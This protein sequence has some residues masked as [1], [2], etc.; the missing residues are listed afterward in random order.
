MVMIQKSGS[1]KTT[2]AGHIRT[3]AVTGE[4][5]AFVGI[6]ILSRKRIYG[7]TAAKYIWVDCFWRRTARPTVRTPSRASTG[8]TERRKAK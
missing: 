2:T 1:W 7:E 5:P 4:H 3:D 8:L 6:Y